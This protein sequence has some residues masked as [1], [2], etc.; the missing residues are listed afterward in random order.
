MCL[1]LQN[2]FGTAPEGPFGTGKTETTK[3]L[4][5]TLGML[6]MVQSG[7]GEFDYEVLTKLFK[8]AACC[9]SWLIFDEFNRLE[10]E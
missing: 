9:G 3:D 8:G 5:R 7:S 1:A 10:P 2:N 4:A 6:C